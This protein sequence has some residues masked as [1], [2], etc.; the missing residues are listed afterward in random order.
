MGLSI[1]SLSPSSHDAFRGLNAY[2]WEKTLKGR[3]SNKQ[4][5]EFQFQLSLLQRTTAMK[6]SPLLNLPMK[7]GQ[8]R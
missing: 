2:A 8:K 4:G 6:L 1:D 5:I 3:N 7:K